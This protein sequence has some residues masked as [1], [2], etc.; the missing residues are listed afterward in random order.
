[1]VGNKIRCPCWKCSNKKFVT[2]EDVE[3][4]LVT[5]DFVADYYVWN[6]HREDGSSHYVYNQQPNS[7]A[8]NYVPVT[9]F[10]K[11]EP[12]QNP[13]R[14]MVMDVAGPSFNPG[15]RKNL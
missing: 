2:I 11:N 7:E 4:Y 1:M 5:K 9:T 13:F 14:T 8:S 6:R 12:K 3:Y 15:V 10:T